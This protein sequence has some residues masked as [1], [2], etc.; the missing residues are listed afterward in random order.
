[1]TGLP[2]DEGWNIPF[3]S[4]FY[5]PLPARYEDVSF[6]FVF[7]RA[8]PDA[9]AGLLPAPLRPSP[10]G[11]CMAMGIRIPK[12]SAYGAFEEAVLQM[13]CH[14][15]DRSGWYCSH[16][17]HNGPAGI[18]A[19]REIYGTPKFLADVEIATS[20]DKIRTQAGTGDQMEIAITS[21]ASEPATVANLPE[22]APSWRLKVIPRADGPGPAIKQLVDGAPAAQDVTVSSCRRGEGSVCFEPSADRD[23]SG[24]APLSY[25]GA[26]H[27]ESSYSEGYATIDHDYLVR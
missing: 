13:A 12:C 26:F 1:M 14:F 10:E 24:L 21:S 16:V 23:L 8:D 3:D 11:R 19:G 25:D 27:M 20:G 9:M 7:F 15:G 2:I 22:L 4:P 6:Q 18:A 5:P 17:W